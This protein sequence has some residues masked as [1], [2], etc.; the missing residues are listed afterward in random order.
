MRS[1]TVGGEGFTLIELLV[2]IAI[3]AILA[4]LL[5]PVFSQVRE[6]GWQITCLSNLKQI[7]TA[8]K[9]YVQDYDERLPDCCCWGRASVWAGATPDPVP[10]GPRPGDGPTGR[11]AQVGITSASPPKDTVL[12]P[13]QNPP[14][15]VQEKLHPYVKNAQIWFCPSVGRERFFLGNPAYPTYGYNG[16]TYIWNWY[17][18]PGN[19][20]NPFR[21]RKP[22]W[23]S[24]RALTAVPN[25][26][27]APLLWDMPWYKVIKQPCSMR[28]QPA[29]TE[30]VNVL[31]ADAHA[32]FSHF[33]TRLAATSW[34]PCVA[35]W[36]GQ[37]HWKGFFE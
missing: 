3:L 35:D 25:P 24:G 17:A 36:W 29:H 22:E 8:L 11:C 27:A 5:F 15:Y 32:K 10:P 20:E 12:G 16:T 23:I 14:R 9:M 30:G 13:E 4:A 6:K 37:H 33:D 34:D 19:V 2:V 1:R 28:E 31:Y 18:D 21:K 26:T 7:G